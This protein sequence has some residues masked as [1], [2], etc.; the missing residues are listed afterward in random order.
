MPKGKKRPQKSQG[1]QP[2]RPKNVK[3]RKAT[4]TKKSKDDSVLLTSEKANYNLVQWVSL[5]FYFYMISLTSSCTLPHLLS[6]KQETCR[7][8]YDA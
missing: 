7:S 6:M 4:T 8:N 3:I 5:L 2:K 1:G